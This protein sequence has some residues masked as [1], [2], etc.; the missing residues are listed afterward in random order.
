MKL[1]SA[2]G[3]QGDRDLVRQLLSLVRAHLIVRSFHGLSMPPALYPAPSLGSPA[4]DS[5]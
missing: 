5:L 1:K 3:K 4:R 2:N